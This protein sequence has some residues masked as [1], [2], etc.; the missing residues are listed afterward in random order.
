MELQRERQ[1]AR[2]MEA[3][4]KGQLEEVMRA[5]DGLIDELEMAAAEVCG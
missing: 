5:N 2:E 1:I 3:A 4:L